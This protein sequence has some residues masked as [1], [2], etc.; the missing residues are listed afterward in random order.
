MKTL[1]SKL[2][3]CCVSPNCFLFPRLPSILSYLHRIFSGHQIN[4]LS[5]KRA[6]ENKIYIPF[7]VDPP[8]S[9]LSRPKIITDQPE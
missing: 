6:N 7:F 5:K 2:S 9:I 1:P 8:P 3:P 4:K